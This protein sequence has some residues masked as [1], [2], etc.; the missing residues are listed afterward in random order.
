MFN[1]TWLYVGAIYFAAVWIARRAAGIALPWRIATFFYLL[2]LVFLWQ[3]LTKDVVNLPVDFLRVL[4][5]W[6]FLTRFHKSVNP[7]I[8]DLAL[9]IVPW[10]HQVREAWLSGH[11]PLW[12]NYSGSGYPLLANAQSSALSPLRLLALPLP[13]GQS[14]AFEAA[15]KILIALTFT[16]LFCRRRY[17][18]LA[19]VTAAVCFGFCS[20]MIVWLHFPLAT[21]SAFVPAALYLIDLIAE[22][23]TFG[24]FIFAAVLWAVMIFGGHPETV[25]HIF[26]ISLLYVGWIA[27][28]E[29]PFAAWRDT[30]RFLLTLG[31]ALAVAAML[32]APFL[33]PLAEALTKSRR[34]SELQANPNTIGYYSDF[35]SVVLLAAPRFFGA[36]PFEKPWLTAPSAESITG[37][38]G[39]L[40]IAA[41]IALAIHCIHTRNWRSRELF[42][43][44]A[45]LV[46]LGVMLG[47]PGISGLFH[48]VFRL[49]ANARL[50]LLFC[51]LLAVQTAAMID[52]LRSGTR[53]YLAGIAI[54]GV[55]LLY[56]MYWAGFPTGAPRV[57]ALLSL[58]PSLAVLAIATIAA[59]PR[60]REWAVMILLVAVI[61]EVWTATSGWNPILRGEEMYP[62]TPLIEKLQALKAKEPATSPS[63]IV[64]T[65]PIFFPNTPAM[66]GLEDIRA[67]DPMAN[68]RYLGMLRVLTGYDTEDYFPKWK[69]VQTRVLDYLNVKYVVAPPR[70]DLGDP[71]RYTLVYDGNDGRVFENTTV[72]PR[73]YTT[74]NVVLEFKNDRYLKLLQRH[75]DWE[76]TALLKSLPVEND[77]MRLD[78]LL[79]RPKGWPDAS[80]KITQASGDDYRMTVNAPRYTFVVSS[81]PWWPGWKVESNGKAINPLRVNGA[82]LGFVVPK[83]TSD[84]RVWYSPIT[85]WGGVWLTLATVIGICGSAGLV[86]RRRRASAAHREPRAA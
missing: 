81:I 13:L 43:V 59:V 57:T 7:D 83:G 19:S 84:V 28:V 41:W 60:F 11:I 70:S 37:F 62:T 4:P 77:Q 66:Y 14:F 61:G 53:A 55:A 34:F 22:R 79:P 30:L 67:H 36:L 38:A 5:P 52:L 75:D 27:V 18:E 16:F 24:R 80:M 72:L 9:Q 47:W 86:R 46:V 35:P 49:A 32:A 33:A 31:G 64:G 56:V 40:G 39:F 2:V 48:L 78:L 74:R 45:T 42:F 10:A 51:F 23:R 29:R 54:C 12:N 17:S 15:M 50:R 68:A 73:F 25:A 8:N 69:N 58:V 3:P 71:Q 21:V 1:A 44:I 26:F 82:F 65:G 85:F 76:H 20:F 63:R 6:S